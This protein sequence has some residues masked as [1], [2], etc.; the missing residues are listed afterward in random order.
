MKIAILGSGYVGLVTAAGLSEMGNHVLCTDVNED[1]VASL[2]R[3][4]IPFFEPGLSELV[5]RNV[6]GRR[7]SF[8]NRIEGIH[9]ESVLVMDRRSAELAK[10]A[11]NSMLAVRISFMNELSQLCDALG[12]DIGSIRRALGS[13]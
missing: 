3:G 2:R 5:A 6:R 8:G 10:Y 7:L 11:A 1:R 12:A 13:D 4:K 9:A